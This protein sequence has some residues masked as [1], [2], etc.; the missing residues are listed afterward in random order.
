MLALIL[1]LA[2]FAHI[3]LFGAHIAPFIVPPY[4]P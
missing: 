3:A 2:A 1:H 4:P